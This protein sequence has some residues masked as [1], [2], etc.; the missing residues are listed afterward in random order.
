MKRYRFLSKFLAFLLAS[1]FFLLAIFCGYATV[2]LF[3][4]NL[5]QDYPY[6][7]AQSLLYQDGRELGTAAARYYAATDI[8]GCP[9][10][11][12]DGLYGLT[13]Y[14]GCQVSVEQNGKE[15]YRVG[16]SI[17]DGIRIGYVLNVE[18]PVLVDNADENGEDGSD[19]RPIYTQELTVDGQSV[20]YHFRY[21]TVEL[22]ATVELSRSR[23]NNT[24]YQMLATFYPYRYVL[25]VGLIASLVL[26]IS[27]TVYLL[28]V[29]GRSPDGRIV[30]LGLCDLPT[31][32]Y[33]GLSIALCLLVNKLFYML[34]DTIYTFHVMLLTVVSIVLTVPLLLGFLYILSA[35]IKCYAAGFWKK[36]VLFRAGRAVV[37]AVQAVFRLL[38]TVWQWLLVLFCMAVGVGISFLLGP[39]NGEPIWNLIFLLCCLTS[40]ALICYSGY[41]F[42]T[43][44]VGARKMAGGD[45]EYKIPEKPL[46]GSFKTCA[47]H[48]N[49]L[50]AA[51]H[52]AVQQQLRSER[53]K[54]ELIT[55]V[56]HDIKTPLTSIVNF[57]D[58]LGKPHSQEDEAQ[59]LD[60]LARQSQ[61]MKKLIE[62]LME[63]SKASTGN[64]A[65]NL[66][67]LNA[68]EVVNQAVGEFSDKLD[69][70]H[71]TSICRMPAENIP[72][73]ADGRL[74]WRVLSNL[75]GNVV[76]YAA[77][78]TRVYLDL[79]CVGSEVLL[80]IRNI[81]RAQL[82][83]SAEELLE[84]FVRGDVSRNTEGSG[85]GLN[86]AQSLMEL[87]H[88]KLELLLDG[89]L[90]KVILRFPAA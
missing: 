69:C 30:C 50:S 6:S 74:M 11:L 84:R 34:F 62:D 39:I 27:L 70:A 51:A 76:K 8:G 41:C 23:L 67:V 21:D 9:T 46:F 28:W 85:L 38:P 36:C 7:L 5:Y 54:A 15:L 87:Q 17:K 25:I 89:D 10:E 61:N 77:P 73:M 33:L 19:L 56:S 65:V 4:A 24:N 66:S 3:T 71:L 47:Q 81:S 13:Y 57:V 90:F 12:V 58:L 1:V 75:L 48:L 43:L 42:G 83:M 49:S 63:L 86:I 68:V 18:Y 29:A 40:I 26:G 2:S 32:V 53:M 64:I 22:Q 88:G 44:L 37:R 52:S 80:S 16:S 82:N 31:D 45:L 60:V 35:Q 72:I 78:N 55:N 79:N 20:T 59:Y 14:G